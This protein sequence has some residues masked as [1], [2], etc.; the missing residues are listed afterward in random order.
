[1]SADREYLLDPTSADSSAKYLEAGHGT[2]RTLRGE[3][4][5]AGED[6]PGQQLPTALAPPGEVESFAEGPPDQQHRHA[7]PF[8][9]IPV[10]R[11]RCD[12]EGHCI[13]CSDE[14][15][16]LRVRAIFPAVGTALCEDAVGS[17]TEVLTGLIEDL[18]PGEVVL[19]H[20][21]AAL[22]K[23]EVGTPIGM[24]AG[25]P[26]DA[27]AADGL[28]EMESSEKVESMEVTP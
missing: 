19:V 12:V 10:D 9:Q 5:S 4:G 27:A 18:R 26:A 3:T 22:A 17:G 2:E 28:V 20:A 11:L 6:L 23:L 21:G 15:V 1:M 25:P 7:A 16:P 14:G 13:T 24:L 8:G